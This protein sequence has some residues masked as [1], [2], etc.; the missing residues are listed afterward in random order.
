MKY[1]KDYPHLFIQKYFTV[2]VTH[3]TNLG[4]STFEMVQELESHERL[5]EQ[6]LTQQQ[7]VEKKNKNNERFFNDITQK[8][9]N[10]ETL[11]YALMSQGFY[12]QKSTM[13]AGESLPDSFSNYCLQCIANKPKTMQRWIMKNHGGDAI[14]QKIIHRFGST[15]DQHFSLSQKFEM[16]SSYLDGLSEKRIVRHYKIKL[17]YWNQFKI[18]NKLPLKITNEIIK[19]RIHEAL[20]EGIE[21]QEVENHFKHAGKK[22]VKEAIQC[23]TPVITLPKPPRLT[24]KQRKEIKKVEQI[25]K[26]LDKQQQASLCIK[27]FKEGKTLD[28]IADLVRVTTLQAKWNLIKAKIITRSSSVHKIRISSQGYNQMKVIHK[29]R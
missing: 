23:Y 10:I 19:N 29:A 4:Y 5:I 26:R 18:E 27:Y 25:K 20:K 3:F 14:F 28:Q 8:A 24:L 1:I 11:N 17:Q 21:Q 7:S 9:L 13:H 12:L 6:S 22:F 15:I 2:C 16:L